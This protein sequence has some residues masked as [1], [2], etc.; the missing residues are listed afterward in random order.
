MVIDASALVAMA[1][2]SDFQPEA[3]R[4]DRDRKR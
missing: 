1:F 2:R 3:E 4:R